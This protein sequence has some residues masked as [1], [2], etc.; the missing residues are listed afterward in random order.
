MP[1]ELCY[2]KG[3]WK[4][5]EVEGNYNVAGERIRHDLIVA[6][7]GKY[8]ERTL[9]DVGYWLDFDKKEVNANANLIAAAPDMYEALKMSRGIMETL[10]VAPH[11]I[12]VVDKALAKAGGE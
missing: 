2:T 4:L 12:K 8:A 5:R 1:D 6:T 9:A 10:G 3:E 7:E 11:A